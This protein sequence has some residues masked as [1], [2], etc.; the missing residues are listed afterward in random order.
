MK[1]QPALE[2]EGGRAERAGLAKPCIRGK[3]PL[4]FVVKRAGLKKD[5]EK[6]RI[7]SGCV[8]G[9]VSKHSVE[10]LESGANFYQKDFSSA[11]REK[12]VEDG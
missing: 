11:S 6:G 2:R 8:E 1:L 7:F 4:R 10:D 9:E 3:R 5:S 12:R